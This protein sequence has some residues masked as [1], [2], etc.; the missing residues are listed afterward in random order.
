MGVRLASGVVNNGARG[1][2]STAFATAGATFDVN[3]QTSAASYTGAIERSSRVARD[4]HDAMFFS[5]V[6]D[7]VAGCKFGQKLGRRTSERASSR[8]V[9]SAVE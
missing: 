5:P 6:I 7:D 4:G 2:R 8:N 1:V 3:C 9:Q